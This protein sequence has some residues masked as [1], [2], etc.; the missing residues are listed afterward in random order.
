[1]AESNVDLDRPCPHENFDAVVQ[2][3][4]ILG[5]EDG[6]PIA[7]VAEVTVNCVAAPQGCG[8]SFRWNGLRAGMSYAHPMVSPDERTM[9]APLRP[10]SADPDFGLGLP[11]YAIQQVVAD[12]RD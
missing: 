11:G 1:V 2:I 3:G 7:F 9:L 12:D 8:E 6:P 10:A 5:E 4:R